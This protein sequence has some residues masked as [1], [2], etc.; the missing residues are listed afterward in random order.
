MKPPEP[1]SSTSKKGAGGKRGAG[2][3]GSNAATSPRVSFVQ[4]LGQIGGAG[5]AEPRSAAEYQPPDAFVNSVTRPMRAGGPAPAAPAAA[6][7][8]AAAASRTENVLAE[9]WKF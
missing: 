7:T 1:P 6:A 3:A 4:D 8:A 2:G 5:R 9:L